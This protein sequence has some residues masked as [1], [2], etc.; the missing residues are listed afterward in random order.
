MQATQAS[1]PVLAKQTPNQT[2]TDGKSI[3]F[4]LPAGTFTDPQGETLSYA[5]S[6]ISGPS[7][8]SWLSFSSSTAT[9]TGIVPRAASGTVGIKVVATDTS[10]LSASETFSVTLAAAGAHGA[11]HGI[12]AVPMA[13]LVSFQA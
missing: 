2:W 6:E 4:M 9:F 10:N 1:P 11:T 13:D 3:S 5:A 7:V 8:A 12:T